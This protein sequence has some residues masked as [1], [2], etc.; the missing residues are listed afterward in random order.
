MTITIERT[1][2]DGVPV[3]WTPVDGPRMAS[4]M[5]RV[6]RADEPAHQCGITHLVEHLA[7]APLTQ[8]PY[9]HNGFVSAIRTA[10][11][12]SGSDDQ[13]VEFMHAVVT[14]LRALPAER[15]LMERRILL[16]EAAG[17]APGASGLLRW[18]RHGFQGQGLIGA[19]EV[20][21]YWLGP[22]T[23]QSWAAEW[24]T[25][26][27]A[28]VWWSGPPPAGLRLDLPRGERKPVA[29][30][31]VIPG[32]AMP[33][34]TDLGG[35]GTSIGFVGSRT[36]ATRL[37]LD[38]LTVRLRQELRFERGLIYDVGADYEPIAANTAIIS[39]GM[40]CRRED[41][42]EVAG[43]VL[44]TLEELRDGGPTVDEI[45]REAAQFEDGARHA[46]GR[47][48]FLDSTA[49][50]ELVGRERDDPQA[51]IDEYV[52]TTPDDV[53]SAAAGALESA[54]VFAPPGPYDERIHGYPTWSSARV[55]GRTVRPSGW[56][57][58][59]RA[60]KDRLVIGNDGVSWIAPDGGANT[61]RFDECVAL[62]H[63]D[64]PI[65]ELWG[66][67]GFRV[68]VNAAYWRGGAGVIEEIDRAVDPAV[69][70]CGEHG[71]GGLEDKPTPGT[72]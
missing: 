7:L 43:R 70:A 67:D 10:F 61:V 46:P 53:R 17:R 48:G 3:F 9:T 64:G 6:G 54:I 38:I 32:L 35:T 14:S 49:H 40:D 18:F 65:R 4:L 29:E 66:A 63:W 68:V 52:N 57:V 55:S 1:D 62:R 31:P 12:A 60:R 42:P 34:R 25:A 44:G 11:H 45:A 50:D 41:A 30:T 71:I 8:Q 21:L 13:L 56:L 59:P 5:F 16:Q 36:A 39:V 2:V 58:G 51:I 19:E 23:I 26:E 33:T 27:N 15:T 37:L 69:V 72:S 47:L 22:E 28:A 20:G 24:M